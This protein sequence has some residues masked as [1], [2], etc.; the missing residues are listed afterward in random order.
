MERYW[1][2]NIPGL[3]FFSLC[4]YFYLRNRAAP[5]NLS[6]AFPLQHIPWQADRSVLETPEAFGYQVFTK[7]FDQVADAHDLARADELVELTQTLD[8]R[9]STADAELLA[10]KAMSAAALIGNLSPLDTCV[11]LLLDHSGSM[12]GEPALILAELTDSIA[13][14]LNANKIPFEVL[15]FTTVSWKGGRSRELWLAKGK[16]VLPGRLCDLLHIVYKP[17]EGSWTTARQSLALM[18]QP[19]S[20]TDK[21]SGILKENVDGEA[22]AWA[23]GRIC[24]QPHQRRILI[25]ISDGAPVDDSTLSTN[26]GDILECH[27]RHVIDEI[28]HSWAVELVA[29]GIGHEVAR[30]YKRTAKIGSRADLAGLLRD[31]LPALLKAPQAPATTPPNENTTT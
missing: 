3:A 6:A 8:N 16:P 15:G 1:W 13:A 17:F 4:T 20:L 5:S 12:R 30:Y 2:S 24:L 7:Q 19:P 25:I 11:T 18:L 9:L 14:A 29:I 21:W 28:E 10:A 22:L 31:G 26:T 23:Y 27:L